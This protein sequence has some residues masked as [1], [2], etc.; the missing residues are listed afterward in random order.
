MI[1]LTNILQEHTE[2]LHHTMKVLNDLCRFVAILGI[3]A[4]QTPELNEASAELTKSYIE[5]Q[6]SLINYVGRK[7]NERT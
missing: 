5:L 1:E 4:E 7:S 2:K 3:Q 6:E